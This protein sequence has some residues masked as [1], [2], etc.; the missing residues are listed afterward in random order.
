[1]R[2]IVF[3][4]AAVCFVLFLSVI[5]NI[6]K[7]NNILDGFIGHYKTSQLCIYLLLAV[8]M[9]HCKE[10]ELPSYK[11]AEKRK[12]PAKYREPTEVTDVVLIVESQRFHVTKAVCDI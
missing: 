12:V 6:S 11:I 9:A 8:V 7:N 3:Y 5:L 2:L 1:M 10:E 4:A